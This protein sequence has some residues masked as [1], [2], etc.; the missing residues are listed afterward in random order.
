M[1]KPVIASV[2]G[3]AAARAAAWLACDESRFGTRLL[4]EVFVNVGL[5]PDSASMDASKARGHGASHGDMPHRTQG[6]G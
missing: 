2:N 3:V 4:I 1:P 5:V 6:Q